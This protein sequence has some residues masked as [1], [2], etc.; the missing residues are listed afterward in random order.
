M[1]DF[2]GM[3]EEFLT[4]PAIESA[5]FFESPVEIFRRVH[6]E[7]RPRTP[8]PEIVLQYKRF[9]NADSHITLESGVI[10][11]RVSDLLE[12]APAPVMEALANILI[13]KLYGKEIS[14]HHAH[15]YRLYLNRKDIRRQMHL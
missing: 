6:Q 8:V 5:V 13:G 7:I 2:S 12:S 1:I 14:R 10:S 11:V 15:R 9:A 4:S 3:Q